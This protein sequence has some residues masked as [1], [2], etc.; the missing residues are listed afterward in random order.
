MNS[1]PRFSLPALG[2]LLVLPAAA[3]AA[4]V[5]SDLQPPQRRQASVTLAEKLAQR[6]TPP[7]LPE[8]LVSPFNPPGFDKP[9][10]GELPPAQVAGP[11]VPP[12]PPGDREILE[13]VAS[14]LT[15]TGTINFDGSPRLVM[16]SKRF[17]VGTRFTVTYNNQDHE[18]ELVAIDRTTFTL[19]YRGEEFTRPIKSVR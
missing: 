6:T 3:H 9:E 10:P 17:E 1:R 13:A 11:Y 15:P 8:E 18:L 7:A 19:R 12:P 2:F 4:R 16:G 5:I 14:Q